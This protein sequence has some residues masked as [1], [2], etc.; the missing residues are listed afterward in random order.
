MFVLGLLAALW[1]AHV[2]ASVSFGKT[3]RRL[4][5]RSVTLFVV[6]VALMTGASRRALAP[7]PSPTGIQ[8]DE[9]AQG[10]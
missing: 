1:L 2:L 3:S 4:V 9:S 6:V 7:P 10:N 8:V 5:Y